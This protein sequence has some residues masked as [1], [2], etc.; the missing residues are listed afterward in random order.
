MIFRSGGAKKEI[1]GMD[2]MPL[3]G[4][5]VVGEE[6]SRLRISSSFENFV[7]FDEKGFFFCEDEWDCD[8]DGRP[9]LFF[10]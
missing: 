7:C 6:G 4:Y 5:V 2:G 9:V 3:C 10:S 8:G 1:G